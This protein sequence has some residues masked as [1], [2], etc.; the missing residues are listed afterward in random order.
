MKTA[1]NF[2]DSVLHGENLAP[3]LEEGWAETCWQDGNSLFV[4][5]WTLQEQLHVC[6]GTSYM[7]LEESSFGRDENFVLK[8]RKGSHQS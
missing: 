2:M 8:T 1:V 5:G 7:N 3:V 4:P 6:W